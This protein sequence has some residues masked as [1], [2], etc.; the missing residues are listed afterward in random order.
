MRSQRAVWKPEGN[1]TLPQP[2]APERAIGYDV[3]ADC[4]CALDID[5][6]GGLSARRSESQPTPEGAPDA[7]RRAIPPKWIRKP[8]S[9]LKQSRTT[10]RCRSKTKRHSFTLASSHSPAMPKQ[11]QAA[12]LHR[13]EV[14]RPFPADASRATIP[15]R[16]GV[17]PP[18]SRVVTRVILPHRSGFEPP[19]SPVASPATPAHRSERGPPDWPQVTPATLPHRSG[20]GPPLRPAVG[21]AT[22][23]HRSGVELPSLPVVSRATLLH[24]NGVEPPS[25]PVVIRA[26]LLHRSGVRPPSSPKQGRAPRPTEVEWRGCRCR[27]ES[28]AVEGTATRR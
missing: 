1:F 12:L 6:S 28:P 3:L 10:R 27:I 26:T 8:P 20:L 19:S 15:R 2:P 13:S 9:S 24:R 18:P 25:L 17:R 23:L 11:S 7:Y 14:G 5:A 16:S 21:R 4:A 22:L